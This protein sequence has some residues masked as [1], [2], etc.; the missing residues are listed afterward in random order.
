MIFEPQKGVSFYGALNEC[1]A[2]I[3]AT[4]REY[5]MMKFNDVEITVSIDSNHDDLATIYDLKR[6]LQQNSINA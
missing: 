4:G 5:M 1:K 6:K 3:K 2:K